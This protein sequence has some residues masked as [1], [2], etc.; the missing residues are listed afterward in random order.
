ME[1]AQ[2]KIQDDYSKMIREI[3]AEEIIKQ[4]RELEMF[5]KDSDF[6]LEQEK[7]VINLS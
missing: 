7:K 5:N 3:E 4:Q 2:K 1:A 6:K